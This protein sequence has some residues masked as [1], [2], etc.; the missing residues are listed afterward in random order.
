MPRLIRNGI[1]HLG[2]YHS[3]KPLKITK[4]DK[5]I[6]ED[7]KVLFFYHNRLENYQLDRL[8]QW[9]SPVPVLEKET[10]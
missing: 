6:S 9:K 8:I 3:Q 4:D 10:T 7:F 2:R 5:I 1:G